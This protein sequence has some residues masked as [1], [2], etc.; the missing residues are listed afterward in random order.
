[1]VSASAVCALQNPNCNLLN[2]LKLRIRLTWSAPDEGI[3][4][5][6]T[7]ADVSAQV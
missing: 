4:R 2:S 7:E 3:M 1:M 6:D 5:I